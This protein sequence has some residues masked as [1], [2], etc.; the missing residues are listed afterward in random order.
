MKRAD[1]IGI[2]F[3][4]TIDPTKSTTP[5]ASI[6]KVS[7]YE[8]TK[9]EILFSMHTVFRIGEITLIMDGNLSLYQVELTLTSD[10]D[11]YVHVLTDLIREETFPSEEG[12][13]RLGS[14]LLKM[15]QNKEAQQVYEILL[16]QTNDEIVKAPI[17]YQLGLAKY[18]QG[19]NR[20][21][22][23]FYKKALDI[24]KKF[25]LP[26]IRTWPCLTTTSAWSMKA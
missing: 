4:M 15:G 10:N 20:A 5:F 25:F 17:Y 24:D 8:D 14:I 11:K 19:E 13:Y 18:N 12:W 22:I 3:V 16:E 21:A 2:L 9:D 7:Y 6:S 26:I 23:I 1:T